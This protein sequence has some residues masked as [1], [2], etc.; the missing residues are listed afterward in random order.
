[1][2]KG[3]LDQDVSDKLKANIVTA[4]SQ[5]NPEMLKLCI[6]QTIATKVALKLQEYTLK[7]AV[8]QHTDLTIIQ[9]YNVLYKVALGCSFERRG[10]VYLHQVLKTKL[11]AAR[12]CC[13]GWLETPLQELPLQYEDNTNKL[14]R[15]FIETSASE[16]LDNVNIEHVKDSDIF[17]LL[18]SIIQEIIDG[19]DIFCLVND[20]VVRHQN[21]NTDSLVIP[22]PIVLTAEF[23]PELFE[24]VY[25]GYVYNNVIYT[26]RSPKYQLLHVLLQWLEHM[27]KELGSSESAK[28]LSEFIEVVVDP[29]RVV[30]SNPFSKYL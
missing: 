21:I 22:Q 24:G 3:L 26:C 25:V 23:Q 18:V 10:D 28:S 20:D 8:T 2:D 27:T 17:V 16:T 11:Q 9:L 19:V 7:V 4:G 13:L 30:S 15:N 29:D 1:M 5:R 12:K 14:V 6:G